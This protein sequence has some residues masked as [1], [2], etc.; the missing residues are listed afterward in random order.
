M[1][2]DALKINALDAA[3][4][5]ATPRALEVLNLLGQCPERGYR[6]ALASLWDTEPG[7]WG[8]PVWL[9]EKAITVI[10]L[11]VFAIDEL[12]SMGTVLTEEK[13]AS[14]VDFFIQRMR[15]A[16]KERL[17]P[18]WQPGVDIECSLDDLLLGG[19]H[20]QVAHFLASMKPRKA[21]S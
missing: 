5:M 2:T 6:A 20:K 7:T 14:L 13:R 17:G 10:N 3:A 9:T 12:A 1:M 21:A 16:D 19:K 4:G 8:G 18:Q 15:F 11:V